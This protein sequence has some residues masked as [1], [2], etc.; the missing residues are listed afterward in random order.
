MCPRSSFPFYIVSY[1]I[2]WVTTFWTNS[3][4]K[5]RQDFLDIE[6]SLTISSS[7]YDILNKHFY[8]Q[9]VILIPISYAYFL[10]MYDTLGAIVQ[11][12]GQITNI[13]RCHM[14]KDRKKYHVSNPLFHIILTPP[15][16]MCNFFSKPKIHNI[17]N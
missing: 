17:F 6:Y 7:V 10:Y 3:N 9:G 14:K 8:A 15:N 12:I 5:I 13:Q 4:M 1:Y 2:K 16:T 11:K